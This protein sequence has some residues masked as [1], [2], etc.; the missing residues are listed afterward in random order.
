MPSSETLFS[1]Q[2]TTPFAAESD[3][4]ARMVSEAYK[5]ICQR[6]DLSYHCRVNHYHCY[7][8]FFRDA[9]PKIGDEQVIRIV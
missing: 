5:H 4:A 3:T 9:F 8:Y 2:S 6:L 1:N 7:P